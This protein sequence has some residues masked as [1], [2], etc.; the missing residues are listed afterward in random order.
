MKLTIYDIAD[1]AKVSIATVSRAINPETRSKVAP[2]TL[3]KIDALIRRSGYAPNLAAKNLGRATFK[4]I[5]LTLPHHSGIF[6]EVYYSKILA[7]LADS[8]L[9]SE[10]HLKMM[11]LK[12]ETPKWDKYNFKSGQGVDGMVVTHWHAFFSSSS[13]L[14]KLNIPI[15][16]INDPEKDVKAH[17]VSGD[18]FMGGRLAAEHFYKKGHRKFA[19]FR[20]PD[21][22]I[23][24]ELRVKGFLSFLHE[25]G[26]AI[27]QDKIFCGEF[28][29]ETAYKQASLLEKKP[30][31]T[32]IF[33]CN[34]MMALGVLKKIN[35][36]GL[37]CPKDISIIGYDDDQRA[38][39]SNPPLTTISVPLYDLA[40]EAGNRLLQYLKTKNKDFFYRQT[41]MPVRLIERSSVA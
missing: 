19:I 17:F 23:D 10:Y 32:A 12:C 31:V 18:H 34:D 24:S 8:L 7:G 38:G 13:I 6:L 4:S 39:T 36:L 15:V 37:S 14:A 25:K 33:C 9:D 5:G 20:G 30:R 28:Q 3:K 29:E 11:M 1:K 40:R 2:E 41:L 26:I 16:I 35:A 21:N 27:G 22:S